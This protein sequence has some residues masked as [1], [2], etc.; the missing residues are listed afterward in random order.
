[1]NIFYQYKLI[2]YR[3]PI[4][5]KVFFHDIQLKYGANDIINLAYNIRTYIIFLINSISFCFI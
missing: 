5:I 2:L 1:M 3:Y 4:K